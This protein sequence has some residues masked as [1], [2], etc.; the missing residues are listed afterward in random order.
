MDKIDFDDINIFD[1]G[2][3]IQIAGTIWTGKGNSFVTLTPQKIDEDLS[4]L[5]LMPMSLEDWLK[6]LKQAD[7]LETEIFSQDPTGLVKTLLRK[8][9][10]QIDGYVQWAVFQRDNF[11]CRYCGRGGI[12]LTVDHIDLWENGGATIPDNLISACRNCN[13]T[14]GRMEYV[15]WI[16]CSEYKRRS[17]ALAQRDKDR[18]IEVARLTNIERLK[19]LRVEHVRS[20]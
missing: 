8:T 15:D 17:Q 4:D 7:T 11:R 5:K 16:N 19:S 2:N 20:R 13:K 14:R 6:L 12:P 9:A 1:F 10:R 3:E 18:N